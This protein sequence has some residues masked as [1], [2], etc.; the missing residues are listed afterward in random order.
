MRS[1]E[2]LMTDDRYGV[3]QLTWLVV[4]DEARAREL[5]RRDLL[6]DRHHQAVELRENGRLVF[7]I[8]RSELAPEGAPPEPGGETRSF[9]R[10]RKGRSA[11]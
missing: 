6:Q 10:W 11:D 2:C 7:S 3:P 8:S 9:R 5:A 4:S 1:F